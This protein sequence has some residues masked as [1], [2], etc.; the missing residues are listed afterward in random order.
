MIRILLL[1]IS[2]PEILICCLHQ[3]QSSISVKKK[4]KILNFEVFKDKN[5]DHLVWANKIKMENRKPTNKPHGDEAVNDED[6]RQNILWHGLQNVAF[7]DEVDPWK[8]KHVYTQDCWG[9]YKHV[10]ESIVSLQ[11]NDK[12]NPNPNPLF[13]YFSKIRIKIKKNQLTSPM[14]WPTHGQWWSNFW[15]QLLQMEQCEARGG[16]Y[17]IHVS[18]YL[19]LTEWPFTTTS[20]VLGNLKWG[21]LSFS[22]SIEGVFIS[23]ASSHSGG[24]EF[25]GII[26]GSLLEVNKRN[27]IS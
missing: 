13:I 12:G 18:Q 10:E 19:T 6:I 1:I 24:V 17:S 8:G 25:R 23:K 14:H 2:I 3:N 9:W 27:N 22:H 5:E 4:K 20:L 26:P 21:V 11:W 7:L 15:T 16:R